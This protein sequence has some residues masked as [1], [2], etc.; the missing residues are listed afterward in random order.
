MIEWNGFRNEQGERPMNKPAGKAR[1]A[2]IVT[3]VSGQ[4]QA[5]R[6]TS[7]E[8]QR[9]ACRVKALAL[10]LPIVAEYEDAAIS[11]A[12]LLSRKGMQDAIADLQAGRADTLITMKSPPQQAAGYLKDCSGKPPLGNGR[13]DGHWRQTNKVTQLAAGN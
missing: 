8:T 9:D 6:G 2:V 12:F 4:E 7:L 11:G 5:E 13:S 10:G 3:R 1:G